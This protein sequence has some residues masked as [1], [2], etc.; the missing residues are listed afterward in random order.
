MKNKLGKL[1]VITLG[2]V[3]EIGKNITVLEYENEIIIIDCGVA[4]P[5]DDMLGIDLVIPDFSYLVKNK[6]KIKGLFVTHG[7]EDHIGSIPYLLKQLSVPIYATRLSLALLENKLK[8]HKIRAKTHVV[9]AKDKIQV[10][11][12]TVEFINVNHSI[13]DAS[14]LAIQTPEGMVVHSG[15]FKIDYTPI[16]GEPI[17][18]QRF[19]ELG[20][21]GVKLFLCESTNVTSE[22]YTV[23]ER[24]IGKIVR[25]IFEESKDQRIIV[26]TFSSNIHR[27][28]QIL[29]F[30]SEHKRK[31]A[32]MG[33][34]M[35]NTIKTAREHGFIMAE[36][37]VLIDLRDLKKYPKEKIVIITTGSQGEPMAALSRMAKKEH[38]QVTI[39]D[40][41]KIILSASP[42]PGN[43]KMVFRV[44]NEL[45]RQGAEV[46]Y[47]GKLEIHVS[48]HAKKEELK[49]LHSLVKP[50]LF[51]PVHGE[52]RHLKYHKDLAIDM[53]MKKED[54]FIMGI[55][56][57]LEV[58]KQGTKLNGTVEAGK[59]F[60]DGLG[61]GDVGNIVLRDR[62]HL[63]EDG[64]IIVV[65]GLEK[66]GG[67][68]VSGPEI[69]SRGFVYVR[70]S[71]EL[72][73]NAR[74][75]ISKA[76]ENYEVKS[77]AD[78]NQIKMLIRDSLKQFIWKKTKR[79]PM[80]LPIIMEI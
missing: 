63:S 60:V 43:E 17:D 74:D 65:V 45:M 29:D 10:G 1:K 33:R 9:K 7:H 22:G 46:I 14:A 23:S 76:L 3:N 57:I 5:D 41:D 69:I 52:F 49:I 62:K 71:E 37:N 48:G 55:G 25:Q 72:M 58:S 54:I 75:V 42:I 68:I 11:H 77:R 80:I 27:I 32:V 24:K 13:A 78:W 79:S 26:A 38:K 53:G 47:E 30:A 12:F 44:I 67:P 28:Q 8:E 39:C 31:V 64:L 34:S 59:V 21:E 40:N 66:G 73:T 6:H 19:S 16:Q 50:E 51:V 18:L 35:V 56:D 70:E 20:K 61:I 4:F 36:E 2:G 15:D